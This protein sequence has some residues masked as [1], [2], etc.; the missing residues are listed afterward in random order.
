MTLFCFKRTPKGINHYALFRGKD[1][2]F[3]ARYYGQFELKMC[4]G[5][6]TPV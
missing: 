5:L 2:G 3:L 6:L 1:F 4:V